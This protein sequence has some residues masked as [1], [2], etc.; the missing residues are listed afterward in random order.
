MAL[1]SA[2]ESAAALHTCLRR[3][4]ADPESTHRARA[5]LKRVVKLLTSLIKSVSRRAA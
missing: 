1:R 2:T 4:I 3:D 5:L